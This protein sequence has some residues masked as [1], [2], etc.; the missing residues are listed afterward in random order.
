MNVVRDGLIVA[1]AEKSGQ[2]KAT[3]VR[4][5]DA[6]QE[7]VLD[8]LSRGDSVMLAGLGKLQVHERAARPGRNPRTGEAVQIPARRTVRLRPSVAVRRAARG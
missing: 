2:T 5:L 4:V 6:M 1:V 3:V 8:A 7:C